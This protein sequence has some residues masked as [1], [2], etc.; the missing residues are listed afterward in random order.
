MN[1]LIALVGLIILAM[2]Y[3]RHRFVMPK[4]VLKVLGLFL[5]VMLISHLSEAYDFLLQ[6]SDEWWPFVKST[7]HDLSNGL[8]HFLKKTKDT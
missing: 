7:A 8:L 1:M 6:V 4:W 2:Y 3:F 5:I